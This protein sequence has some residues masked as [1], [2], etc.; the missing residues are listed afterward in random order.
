VA[1]NVIAFRSTPV[2]Y[3][4]GLSRGAR[5]GFDAGG[6][7]ATEGA[8]RPLDIAGQSDKLMDLFCRPVA[9]QR[10]D[11][12]IW[13]SAYASQGKAVASA[14]FGRPSA[15]GTVIPKG[16][17]NVAAAKD[18]MKYVAQPKVLNEYLKGGLGR[19]LGAGAR[20]GQKRPVLAQR[21]STPQG[22][23]R[24]EPPAAD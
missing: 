19:L 9:F 12:A 10:M 4:S 23:R 5:G 22:L 3:G 13:A 11:N 6:R 24:V 17:K 8:G 15:L 21:G 7:H 1:S 20:N 2:L 18:F 14:A 16:A